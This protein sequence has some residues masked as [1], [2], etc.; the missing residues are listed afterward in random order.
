MNPA[1]VDELVL[2]TAR[3]TLKGII[4]MRFPADPIKST[5]RN[6]PFAIVA[7]YPEIHELSENKYDS[8]PGSSG[9]CSAV[10]SGAMNFV[11]MSVVLYVS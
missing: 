6:I 2:A 11:R 10:T 9:R 5:N 8:Q 7:A 4:T 1:A 3:S